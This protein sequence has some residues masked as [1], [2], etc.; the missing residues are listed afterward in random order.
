MYLS[1]GGC[2]FLSL[3]VIRLHE[4]VLSAPFTA[5][6]SLNQE[7]NVFPFHFIFHNQN[8]NMYDL[9]CILKSLHYLLDVL[10]AY[11]F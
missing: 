8:N 2:G 7:F 11:D 9:Q 1:H 4:G 10:V 3:A 6:C 5:G